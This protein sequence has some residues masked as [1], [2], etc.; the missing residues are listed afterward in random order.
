MSF[1]QEPDSELN[2]CYE[3]YRALLAERDQLTARI[4]ELEAKK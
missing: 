2:E 4:A 1:D 3:K